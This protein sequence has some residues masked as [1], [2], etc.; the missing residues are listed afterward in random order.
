MNWIAGSSESL[1]IQLFT[2]REILKMYVN[3][4]VDRARVQQKQLGGTANDIMK[5]PRRI[6]VVLCFLFLLLGESVGDRAPE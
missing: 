5:Y 4:F 2:T 3:T 1:W 6:F